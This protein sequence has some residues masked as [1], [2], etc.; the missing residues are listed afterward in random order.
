[1][2]LSSSVGFFLV[3][4]LAWADGPALIVCGTAAV[5]RPPRSL[6]DRWAPDGGDREAAVRTLQGPP[7]DCPKPIRATD[8]MRPRWRSVLERLYHGQGEHRP[9]VGIGTGGR[10]RE[11]G[12]ADPDRPEA[13]MAGAHRPGDVEGQGIGAIPVLLRNSGTRPVGNPGRLKVTSPGPSSPPRRELGPN[14]RC[15]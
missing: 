7:G 4:R 14:S 15:R 12:T 1:M 11:R 3:R 9:R 6:R 8:A 2:S 10:L 5:P 13:R